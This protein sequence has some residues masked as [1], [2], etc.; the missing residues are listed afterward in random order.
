MT[1]GTER[2]GKVVS[3]SCAL[4]R[5]LASRVEE[6][7]E[8][9]LMAPVE[10]NIVCFRY[11]CEDADRV[12]DELVIA[13]QESGVVAPSATR[14][15]DRVAIRAALFNHRTRR[16]DVEALVREVVRLGAGLAGASSVND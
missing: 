8:L 3:D 2:L 6:T 14:L 16:E 11:R 13:L 10:L 5:H 9:E 12:N 7:P 1:Y 15:N 4:A